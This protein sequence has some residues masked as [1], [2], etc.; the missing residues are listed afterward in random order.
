MKEQL[1]AA[2]AA[3][4]ELLQKRQDRWYP[5]FHIAPIAG[6]LNDPNGLCYFQGEYQV[7]F[8]HHPYSSVWG[9]MHWGHV[10]SVD[11]VNW[12]RRPIALAP[13]VE[14]DRDGAFSGS[15]VVTDSGETLRIYYTGHR[16]RNGVGEEEGSLQ[17]QM[18]A[19]SDDGISFRDKKLL[20]D[21]PE[22]LLH[23]RDPKVWKMDDTWY[24]VFGASS[25]EN[26]G[27]VWLYTSSDMENWTFDRILFEDPDPNVFM[28]ECPDLF[29]LGDKW[30]L[31]YGP[32]GTR[33]SGYGSRNVYGTGYVVGK[34]E[35]GE[36]FVQLTD[37][38]MSDWGHNYYAPQTLETPDGRRVAF[39]WMGDF[40]IPLAS[41]KEDAWSG[42]LTVPRRL[43][44]GSSMDLVSQPIA[45]LSQLR[46]DTVG[47]GAFTV[48]VNETVVLGEDLGG[49]EIEAE[50]DLA[51]TTS[52]RVG[53][54]VHKTEDGAHTFLGYDDLS[55]TV[56]IDRRLTGNGD[57]GVRAVPYRG[58]TL[59]LRIFIDRGSVEVF[60]NDGEA[61]L[62]SL[63]FPNGGPRTVELSS[64]GGTIAVTS[65]KLH[66]LRSIWMAPDK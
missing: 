54:L 19:T 23:F 28:L 34:W 31:Q 27:Q 43:T 58:D 42:Q 39:G 29:P 17:V 13:S 20:I 45:E 25:L 26:R 35:P 5:K 4:A 3:V 30:V 1:A 24:M 10:A 51:S 18:V 36:D 60:V 7:Y 2:E 11:L 8:Q 12:A 6:W 50:F 62:S 16:W 61:T 14:E 57:R 49:V 40:L 33:P 63:S 66:S 65:L 59:K 21:S 15:A 64:E 41:Q 47:L 38:K 53:F 56:F 37:Y 52:D 46:T 22:G 55:G 48:D 32:M 44:L 9:P